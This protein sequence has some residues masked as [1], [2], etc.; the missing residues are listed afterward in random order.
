MTNDHA[1]DLSLFIDI[2]HTLETMES[3]YMIIGAFATTVYGITRM[4]Y[5]IDIVVDLTVPRVLE[6]TYTAWDL[7]PF[8]DDVWAEALGKKPLMRALLDPWETNREATQAYPR[9]APFLKPGWPRPPFT[10][11]EVRRSQLRAELD[12]LYTHL[13]GLSREEL[14][15]IMETFPIVKGKD[16]A[17]YGEYG[18]KRLIVEAFD[19]HSDSGP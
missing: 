2:L 4:T 11:D 7:Q 3:P 13:C 1:A 14:A 10:W 12:A 18:T 16:E 6:L 8:A 5:N 9:E 19:Q 17:R 15:C